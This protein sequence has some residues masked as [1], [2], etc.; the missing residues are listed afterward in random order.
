MGRDRDLL[1]RGLRE[2]AGGQRKQPQSDEHSGEN[3]DGTAHFAPHKL[4]R[5]E[6][7]RIIGSGPLAARRPHSTLNANVSN[8]P[9]QA[10]RSC[11]T[12]LPDGAICV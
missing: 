2:R 9:G 4:L 5:A 8:M 7:G 1:Y 3:A 6:A 12:A 11:C 10:I